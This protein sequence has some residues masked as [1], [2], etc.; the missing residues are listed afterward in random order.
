MKG[1]GKEEGERKGK[2]E[3]AGEGKKKVLMLN[4]TVVLPGTH[5]ASLIAV[6]LLL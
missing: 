1:N 3:G 6:V 2:G 5:P 4:S